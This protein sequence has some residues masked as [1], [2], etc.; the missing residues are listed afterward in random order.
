[1]GQVWDESFR[2]S[3]RL[4]LRIEGCTSHI[5]YVA[6]RANEAVSNSV[7]SCLELPLMLCLK[8]QVNPSA[9]RLKIDT[10]VFGQA[11]SLFTYSLNTASMHG[12]SDHQSA[13]DSNIY[14]VPEG[15][16]VQLLC[17][18]LV[19]RSGSVTAAC[20]AGLSLA[21]S[22]RQKGAHVANKQDSQ[23]VS[24]GREKIDRSLTSMTV[25]LS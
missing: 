24:V 20:Q 18:D 10:H 12:A 8:A 5:W 21:R 9:V 25:Y 13:C 4:A 7:P 16:R 2:V 11:L 22:N 3:A 15:C 6:V 14:I 17:K 19:Y 23:F 1:M